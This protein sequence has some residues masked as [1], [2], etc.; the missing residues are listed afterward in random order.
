MRTKTLATLAADN[1]DFASWYAEA[2]A[3]VSEV[4]RLAGWDRITFTAIL[5]ITSP[6]VS[7][8][9]NARI[10]LQY[11]ATGVLFT[12]VM[13]NIRRGIDHYNATGEIRGPKTGPF[14]AALLGET[15]AIVL[16]VHMANLFA[17]PQSKLKNRGPRQTICN[18]IR[19]VASAV[20]TSPRD[21]QACLW[22]GQLRSRG[23]TAT[24]FDIMQEYA[25]M[26]AHGGE[27]PTTGAIAQLA[28]A[29]G[30]IQTRLGFA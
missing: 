17:V 13:G 12:N 8:R 7:V 19:R 11:M 9:R 24:R 14:F 15:S 16:D 22:A 28:T 1:L 21:C 6:R 26:L 27:F 25:N 30:E 23:R 3:E 20:G 2:E 18:A 29:S 4:C 10:T 5:A